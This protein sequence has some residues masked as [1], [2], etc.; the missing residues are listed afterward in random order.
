MNFARRKPKHKYRFQSFFLIIE[1]SL[2][3]SKQRTWAAGYEKLPFKPQKKAMI[4][5][6]ARLFLCP[7]SCPFIGCGMRTPD[8]SLGPG[9]KVIFLVH[10]SNGQRILTIHLPLKKWPLYFLGWWVEQIFQPHAYF[11]SIWLVAV[12]HS[13]PFLHHH[14]PS[15]TLAK[16][17]SQKLN[18]AD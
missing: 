5:N 13:V 3:I 10:Q 12:A 18:N 7:V 11:T 16:S 15:V 4:L 2:F 17:Q 6:T 9:Y 8:V 1:G 14:R